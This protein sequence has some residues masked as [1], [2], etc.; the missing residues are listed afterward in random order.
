MDKKSGTK[1]R[2][3]T[4]FPLDHIGSVFRVAIVGFAIALR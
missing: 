4:V 2:F 1:F 3:Q